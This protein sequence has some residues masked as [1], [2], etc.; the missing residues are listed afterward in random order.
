MQDVAKRLTSSAGIISRLP[1][2]L[3]DLT[4]RL[5]E[6]RIS[7]QSP[8]LERRLADL[9]RLGLRVIS[10]ILFTALLIGGILLRPADIVLG[11]VLMAVSALPLLHVIFAGVVARRGP[12]P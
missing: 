9:E 11:T 8:R 4:T 2:R 10:A 12:L 1:Q 6:G 5:N 7:V 3:D